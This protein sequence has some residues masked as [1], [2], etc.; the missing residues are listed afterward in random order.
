MSAIVAPTYTGTVAGHPVRFFKGPSGQPELPWHAVEDLFRAA[1]LPRPLRRH[2]LQ[3]M[4][5]AGEVRTVATLDG[6]VTIAPHPVAQGFL[7]ALPEM[8]SIGANASPAL[9]MD[10]AAAAAQA[11]S[12]MTGDLPFSATIELVAA[13]YRKTR[14]SEA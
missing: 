6:V 12:V 4:Q 3:A 5:T 14:G 2:F 9:K 11:M 7:D 13:A 10:Y 8:G 1:G